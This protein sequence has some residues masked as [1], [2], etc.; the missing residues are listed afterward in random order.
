MSHTKEIKPETDL[1]KKI[2]SD[3]EWVDGAEWGFSRE[4]HPEEKNLYH[5]VEVLNNIDKLDISSAN[6][7]ILR[8][9]ALIHDT[10]KYKVDINRDRTGG[11]NHAT[12]ARHFAEKFI[13]NESVLKIIELHDEAFN[14]WRKGNDTGKWEKAQER[15]KKLL[16]QLGDDIQLYYWFYKCDNETGDKNQ[17]CLKWF[18]EQILKLN[19]D[20]KL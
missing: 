16:D 7:E 17:Q 14:S 11:N 9:I 6:R 2:I 20:I 5:I 19:K 10:F 4:S 8:L 1:E 15:L 13:N 3:P 12:I 18:E